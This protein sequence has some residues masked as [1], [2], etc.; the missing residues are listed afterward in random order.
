MAGK[1]VDEASARSASAR[2][3]CPRLDPKPDVVCRLFHQSGQA[4]TGPRPSAKR[5]PQER[6][7][8]KTVWYWR[9]WCRGGISVLTT[10]H[11]E[12]GAQAP[13]AVPAQQ[14]PTPPPGGTRR[15]G[16]R[17]RFR[18]VPDA[19]LAS[20]TATRPSNARP[21]PAAIREMS[22]EKIYDALA[23]GVMQTQAQSL[24]DA[25]KRTVAEFMSG[26]PLG[27][28]RTGRRA[29]HAEQ[30]RQ[31]PAA[32]RSGARRVVER[33]GRRPREHAV[34]AGAAPPA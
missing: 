9:P 34:P 11:P 15:A 8:E 19:V 33:L 18:D 27:S 6:T 28:A 1:A 13:A 4:L 17:K 31:Q 21:S 7:R 32:R 25:Q 30:V 10:V 22:P 5:T 3:G 16:N 14:A 29:E 2:A 20:V 26:R 12:A 24:S 23:T